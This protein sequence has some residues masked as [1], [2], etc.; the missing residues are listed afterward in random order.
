MTN[1]TAAY[2]GFDFGASSGRA[3]LGLLKG[4]KLELKELSRFPNAPCCGI[5]SRVGGM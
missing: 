2:L 1:S 3:V 5:A 4:H